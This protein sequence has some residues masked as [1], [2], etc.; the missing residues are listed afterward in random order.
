LKYD[1]SNWS[2]AKKD[3]IRETIICARNGRNFTY[4]KNWSLA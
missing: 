1:Q 4:I 3:M 2:V